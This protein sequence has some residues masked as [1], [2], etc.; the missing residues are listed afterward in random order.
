M[1]LKVLS[2]ASNQN[3]CVIEAS[4]QIIS[5]V[6]FKSST[7]TGIANLECAVLSSGN[8]KDV[9]PLDATVNTIWPCEHNVEAK[10]LHIKVLFVFP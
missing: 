4:F 3:L 6:T 1:S 8:N 2:N 10:V 7:R 9:M 5:L